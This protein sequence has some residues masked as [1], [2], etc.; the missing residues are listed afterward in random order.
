M[1]EI[2]F[3]FKITSNS[4]LSQKKKKKILCAHIKFFILC[5]WLVLNLV[6]FFFL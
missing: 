2:F 3:C 1:Y 4:E 5:F 6:W